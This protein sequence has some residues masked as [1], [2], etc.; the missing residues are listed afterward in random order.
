VEAGPSGCAAGARTPPRRPARARRRRSEI[1][2]AGGFGG[3]QLAAV[4]RRERRHSNLAR[5]CDAFDDALHLI[6]N[7]AEGRLAGFLANLNFALPDRIAPAKAGDDA[8]EFARMLRTHDDV[9]ASESSFTL[10][11]RT[12]VLTLPKALGRVPL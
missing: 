9:A 3:E 10:L 11:E 2:S 7:A 4:Q 6:A 8:H 1:A 12:R 5:L